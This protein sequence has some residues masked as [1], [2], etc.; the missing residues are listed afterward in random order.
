MSSTYNQMHL[1]FNYSSIYT[2]SLNFQLSSNDTRLINIPLLIKF[3]MLQEQ[4]DIG[5]IAQTSHWLNMRCDDS[6]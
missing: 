4:F 3:G 1:P 2:W 6:D 5:L